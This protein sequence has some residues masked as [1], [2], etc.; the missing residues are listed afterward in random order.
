MAKLKGLNDKLDQEE[1]KCVADMPLLQTI[2]KLDAIVKLNAVEVDDLI[3]ML[4]QK[5][6][7]EIAIPSQHYTSGE[8]TTG[9]KLLAFENSLQDSLT[10]E[11]D[12]QLVDS[13]PQ[14]NREHVRSSSASQLSPSPF[15]SFIKNGIGLFSAYILGKL[16]Q[17]VQPM[18]PDAV[19][20]DE[21]MLS[22]VSVY[23]ASEQSKAKSHQS[24][25]RSDSAGYACSPALVGPHHVPTM[26]CA[27]EKYTAY[28]MPK[29]EGLA[30]GTAVINH[31]KTDTT[32]NLLD[33][34]TFQKSSCRS[35]EF[36]GRKALHCDGK[37]TSLTVV[38][39]INRMFDG[40]DGQLILAKFTVQLGQK[41]YKWFNETPVEKLK[42]VAEI[43]PAEN[44]EQ[45]LYELEILLD[46]ISYGIAGNKRLTR[47]LRFA[48]DERCDDLIRLKQKH[49]KGM[50]IS[51]TELANLCLD[52]DILYIDLKDEFNIVKQPTANKSIKVTVLQSRA[53]SMLTEEA[54]DLP[55]LEPV[56]Q[57]AAENNATMI[58]K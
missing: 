41:A 7:C 56:D 45:K 4:D 28:I 34:E 19:L 50:L 47:V 24:K 12:E 23:Q 44:V 39:H 48:L 17:N 55:P 18:Q 51:K 53:L 54:N 14:Q 21:T 16:V 25:L 9:R 3:A 36:F 20:Q 22:D 33:G 29:I 27:G 38:P 57:I 8:F 26:V 35:V 52:I 30:D 37:N 49:D 58:N 5:T 46:E 40:V 11:D 2:K 6:W 15:Y 10:M 1:A 13:V 42:E 43:I 32:R 31:V